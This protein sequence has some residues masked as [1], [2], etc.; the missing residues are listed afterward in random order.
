MPLFITHSTKVLQYRENVRITFMIIHEV[1][2]NKDLLHVC[3]K[4]THSPTLHS[5]ATL[6]SANTIDY[7]RV[8]TVT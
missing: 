1:I 7:L 6:C 2:I 8:V 3:L 5:F 4:L